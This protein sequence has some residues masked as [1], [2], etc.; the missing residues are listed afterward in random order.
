MERFVV[1]TS[2][3][4]PLLDDLVAASRAIGSHPDLVLHG[5][6]NTS[7]KST[8]PDVTGRDVPVLLV[9]GSG[10]DL[11]TIGADGFAP[12][13]LDR[14]RELLPPT[15][16][17]DLQLSNELRCAS[18]DAEAP[19][20]SVE[21]LV[22]ALIPHTAVL[23]SHADVVL[24]LSNTPGGDDRIRRLLGERVVVVDYQM[25]GPDL[26]Q[27][28]HD[29]WQAQAHDGTEGIVVLHHGLFAVGDSPQHALTRHQDLVTT[30]GQ[31]LEENLSR[32]PRPA[33]AATSVPPE[34]LATLR[35]RL[36]AAA[37]M[38]MVVRR[39]E[40][41]TCRAFA[42]DPDLHAATQRGPLT[43]DH[44]IWTKRVPMLG[45]DV[46]GYA[47]AYREYFDAHRDRRDVA[48]TMLDPAP[49]VVLDER[50]GM[51]SVGRTGREAAIAQDIYSHTVRAIEDAE[52]LGGYEALGAGHV[53]D[54]EYWALQ[55][56]KLVRAD[57]HLPLSGQVAVVTGAA[58]GIGR[59][60]AEELLAAGASVV[61]WDLSDGVGATFDSPEWLGIRVDVTDEAGVADA[62]RRGVEHFGG[63]D[64]LVVAA[65]IFPPSKVI[66]ELQMDVWR[67]TMA[68]NVDAVA[69]LYGHAA[70]LLRLAPGGGRVVLIA[71]KNVLAPGPGAAAYSASK[72]A[73]TQLSRVAALEWAPHGVRVNMV[74]P[75]AVFD[76]GLWTE[77]LLA[78]RAENYGLSVAEYKRRNLL[79]TEVTSA[80]VARL[81]RAM[82]D[83]TFACTTGAQV[84]IDGGNERVI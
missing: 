14:L 21:T 82:A 60:C 22:H 6:G 70:P 24:T 23:H 9:K 68:V 56:Q 66:G 65:G 33:P 40:D 71:S 34:E 67:R 30:F 80:A 41:E 52:A 25:P 31:Y 20:P 83:D 17:D 29:A 75:D 72:A 47:D 51:L 43:P 37:G 15:R 1:N 16:L 62:V 50:L 74:H 28:C 58:S 36:S 48:L 26:V 27:A 13:R 59:A 54:L 2:A 38:P 3:E 84:P 78:A 18:V 61:G 81:V 73:V 12:L 19:D 77:E 79:R 8:W 46:E 4:V 10:H 69:S 55:Q 5:G 53:F 35:A 63:L 39:S 32:R 44:V 7:V 64:V 49:R 11:A 42:A 45:T 76:T 57:P